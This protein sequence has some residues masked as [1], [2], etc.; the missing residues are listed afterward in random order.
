MSDDAES[1]GDYDLEGYGSQDSLDSEADNPFF[2]LEAVESRSGSDDDDDSGSSSGSERAPSEP[3]YFGGPTSFPQF[4]R[5]PPELRHHIWRLFCPDLV[6]KGR[7]FEFT[8]HNS[9]DGGYVGDHAC[10]QQQTA[11]TRAVLATHRESRA[12]AVRTLPDTLAFGHTGDDHIRFSR[13]RDIIFF[14]SNIPLREDRY[15][16]FV[17]QI[18]HFAVEARHW[19]GAGGTAMSLN[20]GQDAEAF[21]ERYPNLQTVYLHVDAHDCKLFE[22]PWLLVDKLNTYRFETVEE[23]SGLG[24]DMEYAYCWPGPAGDAVPI[25]EY[26][27]PSKDQ[28]DG[29]A[30]GRD[31]DNSSSSNDSSSSVDS[32]ASGDS[33]GSKDELLSATRRVPLFPLVEFCLGSG[34]DMFDRLME[35]RRSGGDL[36]LA[37]DSSSDSDSETDEYESEGI[38]DEDIDEESQASEDEDDLAVLDHSEDGS[39]AGGGV[40]DHVSISSSD[41]D[42][43]GTGDGGAGHLPDHSEYPVATFSSPDAGPESPGSSSTL[44][45]DGPQSS[46]SE[47]SP[48]RMVNRP[49]RRIVSSDAEDDSGDEPVARPSKR[50]RVVLSDSEDS[51]EDD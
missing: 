3:G 8:C 26:R 49:K 51:E 39:D 7:V 36:D 18:R 6:A 22:M 11:A 24:E 27:F 42:G 2:E 10:L 14:D 50:A 45:G 40:A 4:L 30:D 41:S 46:S 43:D 17:D 38:N 25:E 1:G 12:L 19:P 20:V 44:Q 47:E 37:W 31:P 34:L 48:V 32:S 15:K 35:W 5:L 16:A 9:Y 21:L 28:A 33:P 23:H 13:E 29:D